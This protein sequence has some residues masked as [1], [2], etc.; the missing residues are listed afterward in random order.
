MTWSPALV[1]DDDVTDVDELVLT[2]V[3]T[4]EE[5]DTE[6]DDEPNF[7]LSFGDALLT[8]SKLAV[9]V[10]PLVV[11]AVVAWAIVV[12][13]SCCC[14]WRLWCCGWVAGNCVT[15]DD[16]ER[17]GG[18]VVTVIT[19][20]VFVINFGVVWLSIV[21]DE[22]EAAVAVVEVVVDEFTLLILVLEWQVLKQNFWVVTVGTLSCFIMVR[23]LMS[24]DPPPTGNIKWKHSSK[25]TSC[26]SNVLVGREKKKEI[27]P[28]A[29][30]AEMLLMLC[31]ASG[32]GTEYPSR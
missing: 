18:A 20:G 21:T 5:D 10:V 11:E 3:T 1:V 15:E 30:A 22:E 25:S 29:A 7:F 2:S 6:D 26:R 19:A 23:D 14:W 31:L 12:L 24:T 9:V 8:P 13:L 16:E 27:N 17:T 4:L 28:F 32:I